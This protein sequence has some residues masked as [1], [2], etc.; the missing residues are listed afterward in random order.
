MDT[1]T[2]IPSETNTVKVNP[3]LRT[4]SWK[5][6]EFDK[7]TFCLLMEEVESGNGFAESMA[8]QIASTLVVLCDATLPRKRYK[9]NRKPVYWWN[10]QISELRKECHK[11]RRLYQRSRTGDREE[12]HQLYREARRKLK[13]AIKTSKQNCWVSL[14]EQIENDPWGKP[15]KIVM[16][17]LRKTTSVITKCPDTLLETVNVLFP[18]QTL[19]PV[20]IPNVREDIPPVNIE[21][22]IEASTKLGTTKA[23]GLDGVPNIALK[24]A[25]SCRPDLF[26]NL[27]NTWMDLTTPE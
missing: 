18:R 24:T 14:C 1:V 15:Y 12:R 16:K 2:P 17:K 10:D 25:I 9:H 22:L 8:K 13:V 23:P 27:Y 20:D 7:E 21:E 19:L 4:K 6:S 26:I 11:A 3:S 5:P